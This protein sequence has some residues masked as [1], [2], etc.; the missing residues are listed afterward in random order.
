MSRE[1]LDIAMDWARTEGW[2]PGLHFADTYWQTDPHGFLALTAEPQEEMIASGSIVS[3]GGKFGFMGFFIVK[4]E[5]RG[6][7]LGREFWLHRRDTLKARL[8]PGACIGM[9]GVFTM[10]PF[11]ARGGFEFSHRNLRMQ[12]TGSAT[13][14]DSNK[15]TACGPEALPELLEIDR[16]CFGFDRKLFLQSWINMPDGVTV[17]YGRGADCLGFGT[18]NPCVNGWKI[19]PLFAQTPEVADQLFRALNTVATGQPIFLDVPENNPEALKLAARYGLKECFGCAR[20]YLGTPPPVP[21][22]EIY[23]VTTFELG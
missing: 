17:Q 22:E 23:G 1:Q 16:H 8:E 7:G 12:G 20:M 15:V 21:H 6:K 10:Q 2:N 11:Y 3:Y 13:S 19:G 9:D 14:C 5:L 18:I 4:P